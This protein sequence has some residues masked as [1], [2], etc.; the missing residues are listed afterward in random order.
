[1]IYLTIV[2]LRYIP[3]E[4]ASVNVSRSRDKNTATGLICNNPQMKTTQMPTTVEC[5][6]SHTME[7]YIAIKMSQYHKEISS[8]MHKRSWTQIPTLC[9]HI[10]LVQKQTN[11]SNKLEVRVWSPLRVVRGNWE[12]P[13]G[14]GDAAPLD[15]HWAFTT[16]FVIIYHSEYTYVLCICLNVCCTSCKQIKNI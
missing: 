8:K 7:Y 12:A 10:N 11:S 14:M 9:C 16:Y 3:N 13:A 2:L 1:M 5:W 4:Y 15:L 6:D